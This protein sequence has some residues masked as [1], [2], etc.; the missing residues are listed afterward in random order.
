VVAI[1]FDPLQPDKEEEELNRNILELAGSLALSD[2][3]SLHLVHAWGAFAEETVRDS[4][5]CG[6]IRHG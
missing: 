4:S 6:I 1:D 5:S 3:T 2:S